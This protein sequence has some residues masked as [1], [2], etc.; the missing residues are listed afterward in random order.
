MAAEQREGDTRYQAGNQSFYG[1]NPEQ[2][3]GNCFFLLLS[4][5]LETLVPVLGRFAKQGSECNDWR[6]AGKVKEEEGGNDLGMKA[7]CEIRQIVWSLPFVKGD[8]R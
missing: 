5:F 7:V 6:E 4:T 3:G 2:N 1:G 8:Q